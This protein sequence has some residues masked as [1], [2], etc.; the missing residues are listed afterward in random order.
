MGIYPKENKHMKETSTIIFVGT[1]SIIYKLWNHLTCS[2]IEEGI[3]K[4]PIY[5][6]DYYSATVIKFCQSEQNEWN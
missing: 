5:I 3:K 1:L 6:M 4:I 2:W